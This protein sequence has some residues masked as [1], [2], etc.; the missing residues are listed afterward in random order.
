MQHVFKVFGIQ[1][2]MLHN[3]SMVTKSPKFNHDAKR[4]EEDIGSHATMLGLKNILGF[5][6][7]QQ[8]NYYVFK[9]L[10]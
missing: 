10:N 6:K 4:P 7:K 3:D 1:V 5:S 9:I 2:F 8:S